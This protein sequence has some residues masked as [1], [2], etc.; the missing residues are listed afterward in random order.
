METTHAN[1]PKAPSA[2]GRSTR[3]SRP[4]LHAALG[5]LAIS[6]LGDKPAMAELK[7]NQEVYARSV[8]SEGDAARLQ[9]AF[10]RAAEGKPITIAAIGG[11]ITQGACATEEQKRY[12]NLVA[13]W[14]QRTFPQCQVALVNA[15]IGATGSDLG[16]CRVWRDVVARDPDFVIVEYAVNDPA[17][18][19]HARTLEG[20]VRQVLVAPKQPAVLLLFMMNEAGQNAQDWQRRVGEHYGLQMVSYRDALWPEI[21][22]GRL[23]WTDISPDAVHPNDDGHQICAR[24]VTVLLERIRQA[25]NEAPAHGIP[26]L[27]APLFGDE[28][29]RA[30][31]LTGDALRPEANNGWKVAGPWTFGKCWQ[32]EAPGQSISFAV[33]GAEIAAV[34]WRVKGPMGRVAAQVDDGAPQ[35]LE[36]YFEQTW[37]G[38]TPFQLLASGLQPGVHKVTLTTTDET[39]PESNGHQFQ[40]HALAVAGLP[41]VTVVAPRAGLPNAFA[42]LAAGAPL[43]IAY[44]GGSITESGGSDGTKGWRPLT[45]AWLKRRF[46]GADI[47]EVNAAIGGTGS[48]LGAYRLKRD[49]LDHQPNL[50]FIE[51]AVNDGGAPPEQI[52][53]QIE[54]VVRHTWRVDPTCDICLIYTTVL[55]WLDYYRTGQ[56]PP[57]QAAQEEVAAHYGIPS[58]NVGAVAAEEILSGRL[59]QYEFAP[60]SV[61]PSDAG[62]AVYAQAVTEFLAA[63]AGQQPTPHALP[64]P[65]QPDCLENAD[66]VEAAEAAQVGDGWVVDDKE[67]VGRFRRV[68]ASD[69]PGSELAFAFDGTSI[70]LYYVLGP[71]TGNFEWRVDDGAWQEACPFDYWAKL[72]PRPHYRILATGLPPGRHVLRLRI[73][74]NRHPDSKG[75][76][77]RLGYFLVGR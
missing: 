53:R 54:G 24:L 42:R 8:L 36:G 25:T 61:H 49:V 47:R 45:T 28:W 46:P 38:Y 21:Q 70:G 11:S 77:T 14:W 32:A 37:G 15:G 57:S 40:L 13:E 66:M 10:G 22:A 4:C 23:K 51:F 69:C 12:P 76:Y 68:L 3:R 26:R 34:F 48:D 74:A 9:A 27:P 18:A 30:M 73:S 63:Q 2:I 31:L 44:F 72:W 41:R 55:G 71:D 60:D 39:H 43:T 56:L 64:T 17:D 19:F 20:L 65:L 35:V 29:A 1:R 52:M 75:S 67:W 33:P 6:L 5:V 59:W 16:A 50:L 62:Y 7:L 58:V